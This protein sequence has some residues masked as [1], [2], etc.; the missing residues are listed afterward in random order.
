MST[1]IPVSK[2]KPTRNHQ[3]IQ[4]KTILIFVTLFQG[5]S[6]LIFI[7]SRNSKELN[8]GNLANIC[9]QLHEEILEIVKPKIILAYGIQKPKS[10]FEFLRNKFKPQPQE[11]EKI[12]SGHRNW[13]CYSFKTEEF[14]VIGIP[15]LSYYHISNKNSVL[16]WIKAKYEKACT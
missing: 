2:L 3:K 5:A 12:E 13:N 10:S 14:T 4:K 8:F 6:N 15:H 11:I 16:N 7:A 9:W 1:S